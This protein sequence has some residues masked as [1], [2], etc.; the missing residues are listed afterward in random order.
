MVDRQQH[1]G[2]DELHA[3]DTVLDGREIGPFGLR[4]P[5]LPASPD[6]AC[7]I[8]VDVGERFDVAFGVTARRAGIGPRGSTHI[9]VARAHDFHRA[10]GPFDV[11]RIGLCLMPFHAAF[12]S[13]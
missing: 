9:A 2:F 5:T 7:E 3:S 12:F 13:V 1:H 11:Q 6:R 4:L 8:A 10:V